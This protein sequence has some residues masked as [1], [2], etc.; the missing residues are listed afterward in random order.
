VKAAIGQEVDTESLGGAKMHGSI[1]G[2][3]DFVEKDDA[4]CISHLKKLVGMLPEDPQPESK[5][6]APKRD[7]ADLYKIVQDHKPFDVH[8]VLDC[9]VDQDTFLEYKQD[10][11][12]TLVCGFAKIN[13]IAVGIVANQR[14]QTLTAKGE[15]QIGGVLYADSAD[16]A[17][18]FVMECNQT[19]VPILFF[20]DVVGFMVGKDAEESGIIKSGAKLVNAVSNSIVPKITLVIGNSFGA[21]N[22][23]L[24]GKGYDP[25]FILAWPNARYAVMGAEQAASTLYSVTKDETLKEAVYKR[26]KEQID[27]RYGAARGWIDAIIAPHTTRDVL[28]TLITLAKRAPFK[29]KVFHTGVLQV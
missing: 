26:Y 5:S 15:V 12:K 18:R 11:G 22:Y 21:G 8:E 29:K 6:A 25:H 9:I 3:V 24:C 17:A 1:S 20:Q 10:Y 19:K 14:V 13:G 2:T 4:S 16:K 7:P 23:A 27:I 28:S